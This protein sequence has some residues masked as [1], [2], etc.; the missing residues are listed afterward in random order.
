T[1]LQRPGDEAA[2]PATVCPGQ[3]QFATGGYSVV[4][5]DPSQL[6]LDKKPTFGV[7]RDDLIVKDVPRHVVADG[8]GRYDRWRLAREDARAAGSV[9]T[10]VTRSVGEWLADTEILPE[11]FA[12]DPAAIELV[13]VG[14]ADDRRPRGAPFG[15]LVHAVL[16]DAPFDAG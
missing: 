11:G 16:A 12:L 10:V 7:R 5:W 2:G 13:R 1:V 3:H 14:A 4:W 8:R 15:S 9:P 6:D